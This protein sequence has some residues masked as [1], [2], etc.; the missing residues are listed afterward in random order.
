MSK[1]GAVT[2]FIIIGLLILILISLGI[3][4]RQAFLTQT[5]TPTTQEVAAEAQPIQLFVEQCLQTTLQQAVVTVSKQGGYY[6]V[7]PLHLIHKGTSV[8]Y[9]FHLG[10]DTSIKDSAVIENQLSQFIV[11]KIGLCLQ[12]FASF[13]EKVEAQQ[14]R[15]TTTV[16]DLVVT[17]RLTMPT[18]VTK[19]TAQYRLD[20]FDSKVDV[21]LGK[22]YGFTRKII[23]QH[24][25]DPEYIPIGLLTDLAY[26][27][28]F[29]YALEQYNASFVY[30]FIDNTTLFFQQPY[31]FD[32]G[33]KYG[34]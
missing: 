15:A 6:H 25:L 21:R 9:Y 2:S 18:V 12:N 5:P 16:N 27:N 22:M 1:R 31:E 33:V 8:P 10:N 26:A 11:D 3:Y 24:R 20:T 32:F 7:P 14:P 4:F 13:K 29:T 23:S 34:W 28:N 17:T 19:D 30:R